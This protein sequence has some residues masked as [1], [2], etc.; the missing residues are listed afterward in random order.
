[1]AMD[2]GCEDDST[3]KL[4]V[5]KGFEPLVPPKSNRRKPWVYDKERYRRRNEAERLFRRLKGFGRVCTQY[6]KLDIMFLAFLNLALIFD[7][8]RL[9]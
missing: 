3:R 9:C 4:A 8:L 6:E 1:M 2:K 5:D 7:E